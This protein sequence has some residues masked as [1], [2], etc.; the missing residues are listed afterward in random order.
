MMINE[1]WMKQSRPNLQYYPD[2][3]L[4]ELGGKPTETSFQIASLQADMWTW[5]LLHTKQEC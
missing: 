4:E 3:C 2:I 5:N 1:A